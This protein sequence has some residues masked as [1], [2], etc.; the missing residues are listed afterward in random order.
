MD[1][2]KQAP[3]WVDAEEKAAR[4][5]ALQGC[6]TP[7]TPRYQKFIEKAQGQQRLPLMVDYRTINKVAIHID[8][9]GNTLEIELGMKENENDGT[10]NQE[11]GKG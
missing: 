3:A 5:N 8:E 11:S 9:R 10:G 2:R 1:K 4:L 6:P 7:A